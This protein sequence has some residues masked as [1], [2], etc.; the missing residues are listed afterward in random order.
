VF[1]AFSAAS[2]SGCSF[3]APEEHGGEVILLGE[4]RI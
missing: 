3:V 1:T 2:R 4:G